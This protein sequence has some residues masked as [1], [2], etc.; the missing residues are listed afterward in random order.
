MNL[1]DQ[2]AKADPKNW[3][4]AIKSE[5]YFPSLPDVGLDYSIEADIPKVPS[6]PY[7]HNH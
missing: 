2:L 4:W 7:R 6:T 5:N 3:G 1:V